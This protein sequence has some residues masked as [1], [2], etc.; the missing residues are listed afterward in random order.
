MVVTANNT[1]EVEVSSSHTTTLYVG[2]DGLCFFSGLLFYSFILRS[3]TYYSFHPAHYSLI[4]LTTI[5]STYINNYQCPKTYTI[6]KSTIY[7]TVIN[8]TVSRFT[9]DA[10]I[11]AELYNNYYICMILHARARMLQVLFFIKALKKA[12]NNNCIII[13]YF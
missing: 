5:Y 12:V 6:Q 8:T 13:D 1:T 2:P 3:F 10:L 4:I 11:N 9:R 7:Y